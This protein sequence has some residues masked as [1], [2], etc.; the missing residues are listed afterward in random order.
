[1][2]CD[3]TTKVLAS[4]IGCY[5]DNKQVTTKEQLVIYAILSWS[6]VDPLRRNIWHCDIARRRSRTVCY[7][8]PGKSRL[9]LS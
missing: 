8:V 9:L 5:A 2:K 4:G 6:L 1:M 7:G 3:R